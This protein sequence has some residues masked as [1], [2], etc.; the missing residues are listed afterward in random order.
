MLDNTSGTVYKTDISGENN[1]NYV[2]GDHTHIHGEKRSIARPMIDRKGSETFVGRE[3]ELKALHEMLAVESQVAISAATSGMGGVGKTELAVQYALPYDGD[4]PA[5]V[6][7]LSGR[8]IVG[9]VLSY[10]VRMGLPETGANSSEQQKVQECYAFWRQGIAGRRLVIVDDVVTIAD[11][12]AVLPYLPTGGEFRVVVTTRERLQMRR[13]DLG[14]FTLAESLGLLREIVGAERVDRELAL[15]TELC[16]WLGNLPLALELV[17]RYLAAKPKTSVATLLERLRG[18]SLAARALLRGQPM[19]SPHVSLAAA[20]E[21]SWVALQDD[22]KAQELGALLSLFG[23]A[24]IPAVAVAECVAEWEEEDREDA[25]DALV[26]L[27][28]VGM[29]EQLHPMLREFLAVKLEE[30]VDGDAVRERY[31]A[32]MLGAAQEKC[33]QTMDRGQVEAAALWLAHWVDLTERQSVEVFGESIASIAARLGLYHY[34][35]G[36]FASGLESNKCAL[37]ISEKQ[38]GPDHPSTGTSLNNLALFYYATDR[39]TDAEPLFLRVYSIC[40]NTLGEDHP[41]TQTVISNFNF[42]VQQV[43]QSG[44]AD[45]LS[46]HPFTRSILQQI[47]AP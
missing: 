4:Y 39:Y 12:E 2:G 33:E 37:A 5:G 41:N 10:A 43:Y 42:F 11:Y 27:H 25:W 8:D 34:A 47:Q 46:E 1:T 44:Q 45:R 6:W 36:L 19:T 20:F 32:V 24:A 35:Q 29:D 28:L 22:R 7:W 23:L 26:N 17:G 40:L 38:L 21:V 14:V 16:E 13:L 15:A 31:V 18:Q 30:R 9:Q 3:S